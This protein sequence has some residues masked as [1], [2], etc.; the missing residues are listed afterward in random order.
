MSGETEAQAGDFETMKALEMRCD[1]K[2]RG[3]VKERKAHR[4]VSR[5]V[6]PCSLGGPAHLGGGIPAATFV[7]GRVT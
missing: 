6:A 1:N 2:K 5:P 3:G 4:F 7:V